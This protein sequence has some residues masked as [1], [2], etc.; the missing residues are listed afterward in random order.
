MILKQQHED[1]ARKSL[2]FEDRVLDW[3]IG[4]LE[5]FPI[6]F[7]ATATTISHF[8]SGFFKPLTSQS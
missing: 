2:T 3:K 7:K 8:L 6:G 5:S 1:Q 4:T